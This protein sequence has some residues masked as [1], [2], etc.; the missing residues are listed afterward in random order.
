LLL[1]VAIWVFL[2]IWIR[3]ATARWNPDEFKK[4]ITQ[5]I[6]AIIWI[7]IVGLAWGLVTLV[8]WLNL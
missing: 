2:F 3:I 4:S 1:L 5:L 7:F 8:S 6:Y